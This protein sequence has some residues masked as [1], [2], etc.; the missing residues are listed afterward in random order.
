[1][2]VLDALKVPLRGLRGKPLTSPEENSLGFP[3]HGSVAKPTDPACMFDPP[4]FGSPNPTDL[5]N[6]DVISLQSAIYKRNTPQSG[7]RESSFGFDGVD[8][9]VRI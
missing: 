4:T 1:M 3:L 8:K 5:V 9:R 7:V 2:C 6:W